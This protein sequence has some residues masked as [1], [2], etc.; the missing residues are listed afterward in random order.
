[1]RMPPCPHCPDLHCPICILHHGLA[2]ELILAHL[3]ATID[4]VAHHQL[5]VLIHAF[6]SAADV[7]QHIL[8]L[9]LALL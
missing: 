4:L 3:H 7:A 9:I 2:C 5:I 1:M 6:G 8:L